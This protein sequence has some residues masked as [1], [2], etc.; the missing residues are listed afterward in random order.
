MASVTATLAGLAIALAGFGTTGSSSAEAAGPASAG[1]L[2]GN[3]TMII[4]ARRITE[5]QYRNAIAD[6]F[7]SDIK[8]DGRF[9]PETRKDGL[10]AIGSAAASISSSGFEQYFAIARQVADQTL[11]PRRRD[12][13]AGCKPARPDTADPACT[14]A[15]VRRYGALLFRRPI[16]DAQVAARVKLAAEG[17]ERSGDYYAGLRL[18]L[19]S[20]LTAPDFLFRIERAEVDPTHPDNLRLDAYSKASRLSYLFWDAGPDAGLMRAAASGAIHS[21]QG[22]SAEITRLAASPR[23]ESGVRAFF[24]DMLQF[25]RFESLTKDAATYP[26]F[27]LKVAEDAREQTLKTIVDQLIT[28]GGDYRDLYTSRQTFISRPLAAVYNVPYTTTDPWM[29]YGFSEE[30]GQSGLLTQVTFM[31]LF[32]HPGRSSPTIRGVRLHEIFMCEPTPDPPPDVDFSKVRDNTAGTVRGRL[33]QHMNNPGCA[34]CHRISDPIGLALEEFDG[35]GQRRFIEN[36]QKIDVSAEI[37]GVKFSGAQGLGRFLHDS[38]KLP[39]CLVRDLYAYGVGRAWDD[40]DEDYLTA[41][42]KHFAA[43]GYRMP[44]LMSRLATTPQFF[45]VMVPAGQPMGNRPTV[46]GGATPVNGGL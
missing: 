41:E 29:A 25:E 19:V 22:L 39:S 30:S 46:A 13:T 38:P 26:K 12:Q 7:G 5:P 18:A 21:D 6:I 44:A 45:R 43:S 42:L 34:S 2:G 36:G 28:R 10:I 9:E 14:T 31:S 17:A 35:I 8:V 3:A 24:T 16:S 37:D 15:V 23:L 27:G 4:A 40:D 32:S 11:D 20:L 1:A 33:T